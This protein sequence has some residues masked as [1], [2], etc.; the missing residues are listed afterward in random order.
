MY[1]QPQG[2]KR[3]RLGIIFLMQAERSYMYHFD[4][5]LHVC[6]RPSDFMTFVHDF[7]PVYSP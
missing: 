2:K 1:I 7:I 6:K 4:H 5:G 3:Q